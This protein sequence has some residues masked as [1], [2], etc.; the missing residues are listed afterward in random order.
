[1]IVFLGIIIFYSRDTQYHS[2]L[3]AALTGQ[4]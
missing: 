3:Y 1:M 2:T 4:L